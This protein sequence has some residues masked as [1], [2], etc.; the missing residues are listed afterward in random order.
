MAAEDAHCELL[1]TWPIRRRRGGVASSGVLLAL[2]G[3]GGFAVSFYL[4]VILVSLPIHLRRHMYLFD[5][6]LIPRVEGFFKVSI[7]LLNIPLGIGH[8]DRS[9]PVRAGH[10]GR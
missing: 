1:R 4:R 3:E 6:E 7:H 8:D 5:R 9:L 2:V 10:G